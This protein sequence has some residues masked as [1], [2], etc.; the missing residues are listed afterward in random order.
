[1]GAVLDSW[2]R[3]RRNCTPPILPEKKLTSRAKN[4]K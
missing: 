4:R 3:S 2:P 1:V